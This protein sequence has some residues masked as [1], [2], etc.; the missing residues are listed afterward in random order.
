MKAFIV[1][2]VIRFHSS[3]YLHLVTESV[4]IVDGS[5]GAMIK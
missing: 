5:G 1:K 3:R 2:Y 4:H